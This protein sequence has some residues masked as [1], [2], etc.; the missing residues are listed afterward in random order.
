MIPTTFSPRKI[1]VCQLRQIG[2][3]V[4][5]T[6]V[7]SLLAKLYP[8]AAIHALTEQKC[9]PILENNPNIARI[10]PLDKQALKPFWREIAFYKQIEAEGFELVVDLQ[11]LPRCQR[12]V[13]FSRAPVR[14][15][16]NTPWYLRWLYTHSTRFD[17]AYGCYA[18]EIKAAALAPLGIRWNGER[19]TIRLTD[20]EKKNAKAYLAS[21]GLAPE[22][23]LVAVDATHRRDVRRWSDKYFAQLLSMAAAERPDLRFQLIYAPGEEGIVDTIAAASPTTK[24]LLPKGRFLSLREMAA[25]VGEARLLFG[26][27]SAPRHIA[28]ALDIPSLSVQG[29]TSTGWVFPAPE[30]GYISMGLPCQPC[31]ADTCPKGNRACMMDLTPEKVLPELLR[32][33][34]GPKNAWINPETRQSVNPTPA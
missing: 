10:W 6:P 7:F 2:D 25:C 18:V 3:V 28:V 12:A 24:H 33:L 27:C 9:V 15:A 21:Q 30:H 8:D 22:H 32:R 16:S 1:L 13:F 23:T 11:R 4:L 26:N 14:L 29:P 31:N 34:Q 17:Q 5:S 20:E 19:P